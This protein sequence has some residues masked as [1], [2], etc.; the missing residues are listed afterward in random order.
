M[1]TPN[2]ALTLAFW[3]HMIAT[4]AWIGSLATVALILP[5]ARR[6]MDSPAYADLLSNLQ[7][8]LDPVGWLS[9]VLLIATGMIQMSANPNYEGFLA[10]GN[11]WAAAILIKHLVIGG[12]IGVSAYLTWGVLPSL[13]RTALRRMRGQE[14][15]EVGTLQRREEFLLRLNLVLGLVVLALTA[16]AR[17]S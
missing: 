6:S 3:I 2:W 14:T 12:M 5:V 11:R 15:P 7:K 8:R 10:I 17:S 16:V 1:S 13:Q 9:L 4:V